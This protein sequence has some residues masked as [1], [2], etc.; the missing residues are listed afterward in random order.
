MAFNLVL[1]AV[2]I[3]ENGGKEEGIYICNI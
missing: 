3:A 1:S 2:N